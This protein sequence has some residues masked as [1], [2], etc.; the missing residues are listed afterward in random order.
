MTN[1]KGKREASSGA[2]CAMPG[3]KSCS[4]VVCDWKTIAAHPVATGTWFTIVL[5]YYL[6][7]HAHYYYYY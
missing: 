4:L 3:S 6:Y 5:H 7:T 1:S 2:Y